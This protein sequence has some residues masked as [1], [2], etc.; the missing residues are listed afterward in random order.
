MSCECFTETQKF[1]IGLIAG[2]IF[3]IYIVG[4]VVRV[5]VFID[6][7]CESDFDRELRSGGG[8]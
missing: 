7:Y 6:R 3:V 5:Q 8:E 4:V 1:W 2:L